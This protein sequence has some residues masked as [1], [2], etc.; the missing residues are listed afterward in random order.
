MPVGDN[1]K[2]FLGVIVVCG[3]GALPMLSSALAHMRSLSPCMPFA[4]L[5]TAL[6]PYGAEKGK[7]YDSMAE[8]L[9]AEKEMKEAAAA[10]LASAASR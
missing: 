3:V 2:I 7:G 6:R 8:K 10:R 1:A 4:S 9:A 5:R